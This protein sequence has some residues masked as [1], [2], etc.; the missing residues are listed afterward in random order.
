MEWLDIIIAPIVAIVIYGIAYVIRPYITYEENR[1]FFIPA[2]SAKLAGAIVLGM[3]YQYYY[4][5]GDTFNFFTHGAKHVFNAFHDNPQLGLKLI[6]NN[7]NYEGV[8]QYA[9][10]IWMYRDDTSYMVVR[11]ASIFAILTGGTYSGTAL[12]FALV[13][14]SGLWAM[15]MAFSKLFPN[16]LIGLAIAILF[17]PSTIIWGSG[18][19]KDTITF[20]LLGWSTAALIHIL[21]WR[22]N[23]LMW[24]LILIFSMIL[25][26]EIKEYIVLSFIPA[27]AAW[28]YFVWIRKI[29]NTM[30]RIVVAPISIVAMVSIAF[31]TVYKVGENSPRYSL[32]NL[33]KTAQV[34]AYDI[35]RW[36]GK[37]AGSRYDLGDF[38]GTIGSMISLAPQA[39]NVALFRPYLWEVSNPLM[40]LASLEGF[41]LLVLTIIILFRVF[42][43]KNN[44]LRSPAVWFALVYSLTFAFAVGISTYNFG[45]LFRYKVPLMPFYAI[46]IVIAWRSAYPTQ[47]IPTKDELKE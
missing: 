46:L 37:S 34:T 15:Y 18:I 24:S 20:G 8:Y 32:E 43:F 16:H 47:S 44:I 22:R 42:W 26:F 4:G 38:D 23:T 21:Y 25:S 45:T 33:A 19:L 35:G 11:I 13:S 41:V 30:I 1:M 28:V 31:Y 12:L 27:A 2:L 5:G 9:S 29:R 39:I 6:F 14:F 17:V 10:K 7:N 36:T 3:L 40:L